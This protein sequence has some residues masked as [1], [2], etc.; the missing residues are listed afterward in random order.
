MAVRFGRRRAPLGGR[1]VRGRR[2]IECF[3]SAARLLSQPP[4]IEHDALL[5]VAPMPRRPIPSLAAALVA[6]ALLL[7]IVHAHGGHEIDARRA[8]EEAAAVV[9][10]AEA[11]QVAWGGAA[12]PPRDGR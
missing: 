12:E 9:A 6:V 10:V 1:H 8:L 2:S 4:R 5:E 3:P 7:P 11:V